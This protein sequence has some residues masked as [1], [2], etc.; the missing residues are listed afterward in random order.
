M[1]INKLQKFKSLF[2]GPPMLVVSIVS[3]SGTGCTAETPGGGVVKLSGNMVAAGKKA[4]AQGGVV[5]REAPNLPHYEIE[6]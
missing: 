6:V 3:I 4:Y 5:L 1:A 2:S